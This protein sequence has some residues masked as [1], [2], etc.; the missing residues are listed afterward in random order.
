MEMPASQP[1]RSLYVK[2]VVAWRSNSQASNLSNR[3]ACQPAQSATLQEVTKI[4]T[5]LYTEIDRKRQTDRRRV[6]PAYCIWTYFELYISQHLSCLTQ[7][8]HNTDNRCRFSVWYKWL[9]GTWSLV[10][11]VEFCVWATWREGG[12]GGRRDWGDWKKWRQTFFLPLFFK[13]SLFLFDGTQK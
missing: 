2:Y 6:S 4:V 9:G 13:R 7:H 11:K 1:A 12:W 3:P 5:K 10:G 8:F